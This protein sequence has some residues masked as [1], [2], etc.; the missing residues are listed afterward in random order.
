MHTL[1]VSREC[2]GELITCLLL[3][4]GRQT[5]QVFQ[6]QICRDEGQEMRWWVATFFFKWN[7]MTMCYDAVVHR[8]LKH[9]CFLCCCL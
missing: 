9:I 2:A 7:Y 5:K 6:R 8:Y 1:L 3:I 4:V